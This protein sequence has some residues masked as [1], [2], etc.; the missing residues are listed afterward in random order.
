VIAHL[1]P[2]SSILTPLLEFRILGLDF[3][4]YLN[5]F[6]FGVVGKAGSC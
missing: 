2:L 5:F 1:P 4:S 3:Q 6:K